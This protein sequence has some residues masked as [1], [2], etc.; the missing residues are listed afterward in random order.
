MYLYTTRVVWQTKCE[1]VMCIAHVSHVFTGNCVHTKVVCNSA[2][3]C[4]FFKNFTCG[5]HADTRTYW[6][7]CAK[8]KLSC[9]VA[10]YFAFTIYT[11]ICCQQ[12][13]YHFYMTILCSPVQRSQS[14]LQEINPYNFS[15]PYIVVIYTG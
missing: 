7:A 12:H 15:E 3:A 13:L 1:L 10:A 14:L 4:Q 8:F 11:C 2:C 6:H 5:K 9:T